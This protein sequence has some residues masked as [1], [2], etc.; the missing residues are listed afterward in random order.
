MKNK[1]QKIYESLQLFNTESKTIFSCMNGHQYD[2]NKIEALNIL[3]LSIPTELKKI[4]VFFVPSFNSRPTLRVSLKVSQEMLVNDILYLLNL[5]LK[6]K[7]KEIDCV[8]IKDNRV[9]SLMSLNQKILEVESK[10]GFLFCYEIDPQQQK[11]ENFRFLMKIKNTNEEISYP[12]MFTMNEEMTLKDLKIRVY[13]F[14]RRFVHMPDIL[15]QNFAENFEN[16]IEKVKIGKDREDYSDYLEIIKNEYEFLFENNNLAE[17]MT[18]NV[19]TFKKSLPFKM[20]IVSKTSST[21]EVLINNFY[22]LEEDNNLAHFDSS[23]SM[24]EIK[25]VFYKAN[26]LDLFID[27]NCLS[28]EKLKPLFKCYPVKY[29]E[30]DKINILDCFN[31][32]SLTTYV[33]NFKKDCI[34]CDKKLYMKRDSLNFLPNLLIIHFKNFVGKNEKILSKVEIEIDNFFLEINDSNKPIN[35]SLYAA[36]IHKGKSIE[37]GHFTAVCKNKGMWYF[38]DDSHVE[39]LELQNLMKKLEGDNDENTQPYILFYKRKPDNKIEV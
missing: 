35:Y 10:K 23:C 13:G 15:A 39:A 9:K 27:A 5:K 8:L 14:M 3:P 7:I 18:K 33:E 17:D 26:E 29:K 6:R 28:E 4:D 21:N 19:E 16:H 34:E 37:S 32:F 30:T 11:K 12:R 1:N 20:S 2:E 22:K 31:Q 36:V 25:S 38:F 24:K